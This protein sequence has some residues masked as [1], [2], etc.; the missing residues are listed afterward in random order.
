MADPIPEDKPT[1]QPPEP[2]SADIVTGKQSAVNKKLETRISTLEDL[3]KSL[4]EQLKEAT[5]K[6][7]TLRAVPSKTTPGKTMWDDLNDF[8][9]PKTPPA[10]TPQA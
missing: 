1:P 3:N 6:I 9:F 10:N 8:I 5:I 7:E 2:T 4:G